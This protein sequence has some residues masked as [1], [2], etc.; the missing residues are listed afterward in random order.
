VPPKKKKKGTVRMPWKDGG[1]D[2]WN[3]A[4]TS[5]G[6]QRIYGPHKLRRGKEIFTPTDF[7]WSIALPAPWFGTS[8]L[9][10]WEIKFLMLKVTQFGVLCYSR[11][12][13]LIILPSPP[14]TSQRWMMLASINH[15]IKSK[16]QHSSVSQ[17]WLGNTG[18][19]QRW[20]TFLLSFLMHKRQ[21]YAEYTRNLS[22]LC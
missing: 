8:R 15:Q 6:T 20:Y 11:H 22:N 17:R 9:L 14:T 4:T 12:L 13:K 21:V 19:W 16:H 10:N 18:Q 2:C 7:K 5:Q 3:L 1:R